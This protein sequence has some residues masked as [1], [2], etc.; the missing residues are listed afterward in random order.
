M[1][2][3]SINSNPPTNKFLEPKETV[4]FFRNSLFFI[5]TIDNHRI[6][7]N[8]PI[9]KNKPQDKF[10]VSHCGIQKPQCGI[11][12]S[13]CGT[14]IPQC[15]TE[16]R[17]RHT[18]IDTTTTEFRNSSTIQSEKTSPRTMLPTVQ[19]YDH[20]Y[21]ERGYSA[22]YKAHKYTDKQIYSLTYELFI[23]L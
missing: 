7:Q 16:K 13:H 6:I 5:F 15:G 10:S 23:I 3:Y 18:E 2:Y 20:P 1:E 9:S 14:Q 8:P 11:Y 22:N 4:S 12:I 21:L 17:Q 19:R